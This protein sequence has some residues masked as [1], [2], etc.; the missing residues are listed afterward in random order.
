MSASRIHTSQ[1]TPH[2]GCCSCLRGDRHSAIL[3]SSRRALMSM[4]SIRNAD[5]RSK[6]PLNRRR[7][8]SLL[9]AP[10]PHYCSCASRSF[11]DHGYDD[12]LQVA[13][14][15]RIRAATL[16][17][18]HTCVAGRRRACPAEGQQASQGAPA[19]HQRRRA[20]RYVSCPAAGPARPLIALQA[21]SSHSWA[22]PAAE[23]RRYLCACHAH[24]A[25]AD[26]ARNS[27]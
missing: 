21:S 13:R 14:G 26:H 5:S 11:E 17:R 22:R 4:C 1:Y 6:A 15:R 9:S 23:K 10:P 3:G 16:G 24:H 2:Q 25:E 18:T 19:G 27:S 20:R 7:L 12:V 8:P